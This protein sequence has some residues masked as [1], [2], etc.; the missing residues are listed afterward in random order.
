MTAPA[1]YYDARPNLLPAALAY[2]RKFGWPVFPVNSIDE[3]GR[4]TCGKA[5]CGR[6]GKHPLGRLVPNG[7]R[8]ASL[9]PVVV[10]NWWKQAPY[11]N[12]GIP[13]GLPSGLVALDVDTAKAGD[14]SLFDLEQ[15][16]GPLPTTPQALT[17][18]GGLHILFAHPGGELRIKNSIENLGPGLDVRG[19]G[20]YIIAAPSSHVSGRRYEWEL[21][22]H[23]KD[24]PRA[25][26]PDWLLERIVDTPRPDRAPS[27]PGGCGRLYPGELG[28]IRAA[29]AYLDPEPYNTW[30]H[31]GMALHSSGD[32]ERG[33]A[34]WTEWA[35]K[36]PKFD[37]A[38]HQRR[39][40][41]FQRR[42]NGITLGTLFASARG[43]G[44]VPPTPAAPPPPP[45]PDE[46]PDYGGPGGGGGDDDNWEQFLYCNGKDQP[47]T[48]PANME[49]I[50]QNHAG[51]QG[52]LA[53]D[54]MAYRTIKRQPP[55]YPNGQVG[56]WSDADDTWT[57]IW[58]E[59]KYGLRP[60]NTAVAQV[61]AA[62]GQAHRFHQVTDWLESLPP[63]DGIERLPTFFSDFCGAIQTAYTNAVARSFFVSAVA[64]VYRPGC[65]VDTMLVLEGQQGVG[66][67]RLI[68][69]LFSAKWHIEV[70]YQP[71]TL[72][73]YQSLR[74]TWCAEFGELAGFDKSDWTRLKQVLTQVQDTYRA[75]YGHHAGT[76]PRQSIFVGSTNKREW[77][78]DETGMRRFLP[79][80][81]NKINVEAVGAIREQLW[82]EAR[83]RFKAGET[84]WDIPDAPQEQEARYDYDAWEELVAAWIEQREK[85]DTNPRFSVNDVYQRAIHGENARHI[86]PI[87]R[88]DQTRLGRVLTRLGWQR[89][90]APGGKR[91][92]YYERE[93]E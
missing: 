23:P 22:R 42:G 93:L 80:W 89:K 48:S 1:H 35:G 37:L 84:W 36:S 58:L 38:D 69:T 41:S 7:L 92:Y 56:E 45:P 20:G 30:I 90:R 31:I 71:G 29:L 64:R 44:Y 5:D 15:R 81:C 79:I 27:G 91:D 25:A 59:R 6:P 86:P 39:W 83:T 57:A 17:G 14:D 18:G 63:W 52:V 19:D 87:S 55:P 82:S 68:L 3:D 76:F 4:C 49:T 54:D 53:Y 40:A 11:A 74:G 24:T 85:F 65:K 34:L 51:W 32:D 66:K 70:S 43:A 9:D 10:A 75:S 12:I 8:G 62:T 88:A 60:R 47:V 26:V 61:V 2:V 16:F 72:D 73:F 67:S 13:T 77:G 33:F 78:I 28:R 46:P 21:S 50:F